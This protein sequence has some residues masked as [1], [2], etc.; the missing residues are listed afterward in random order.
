MI[1]LR[2]DTKL[3]S[4]ESIWQGSADILIFLYICIF[5]NINEQVKKCQNGEITE[6][7]L[8]CLMYALRKTITKVQSLNVDL[9]RHHNWIIVRIATT[10]TNSAYNYTI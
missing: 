6:C 2:T 1:D 10:P 5:T 9:S 7:E 8:S 3:E 4:K